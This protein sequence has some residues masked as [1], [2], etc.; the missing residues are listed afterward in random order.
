L[1]LKLTA[2]EKGQRSVDNHM[3]EMRSKQK[4]L[5]ENQAKLDKKLD[6][7]ISNLEKITRQLP[8]N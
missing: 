6:S 2:Q 8:I 3:E 4:V 1:I 5:E 7:I